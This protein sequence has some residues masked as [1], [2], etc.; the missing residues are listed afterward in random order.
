MTSSV[1]A[2]Q[3]QSEHTLVFMTLEVIRLPDKNK[4]LKAY[5]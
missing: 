4:V 2:A 3:F 1:K 5:Q